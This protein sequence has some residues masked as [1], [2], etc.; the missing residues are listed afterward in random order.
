MKIE[1]TFSCHTL[2][3]DNIPAQD[4]EHP[5]IIEILDKHRIDFEDHFE[6][7]VDSGG[8]YDEDGDVI[9]EFTL[10]AADDTDEE[11]GQGIDYL[12]AFH[13]KVC[14]LMK[15]AVTDDGL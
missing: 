11:I 14:T 5:D 10:L 2:L 12:N 3:S 15:K 1:T 13:E 9:H 8:G 6:V 4:P 7:T